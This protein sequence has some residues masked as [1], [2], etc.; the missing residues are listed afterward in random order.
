MENIIAVQ[1]FACVLK[2]I[3]LGSISGNFLNQM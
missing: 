3:D 1:M 2:I